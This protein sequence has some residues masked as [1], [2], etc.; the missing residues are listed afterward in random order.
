MSE[1]DFSQ[2]NYPGAGMEMLS[3]AVRQSINPA[4]ARDNEFEARVLTNPVDV[5][6][7]LESEGYKDS[8]NPSPKDNDKKYKFYVQIKG[9][10]SHK[11]NA[12]PCADNPA[13]SQEKRDEIHAINNLYCMVITNHIQKPKIGDIVKI[14]LSRGTFHEFDTRKAKSYLGIS[15]ST[16]EAGLPTAEQ[17]QACDRLSALFDGVSLDELSSTSNGER[18][19]DG[20]YPD[21]NGPEVQRIY[22]LWVSMGGNEETLTKCGGIGGYDVKDCLTKKVA[23]RSVTLHPDFFQKAEAAMN[24]ARKQNFGEKIY[25]GSSKR[26]IK[27]Q[28]RLRLGNQIGTLT[29]KQIVTATSSRFDPPTA[30]LVLTL[31]TGSRH[32]Y[33]LAIDFGGVLQTG[34]TRAAKL[35]NS[36][37]RKSKTFRWMKQNVHKGEFLNTKSEPWHWS[38]DGG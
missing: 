20:K 33:G 37:A 3:H 28:I 7:D 1:I 32:L 4:T 30:P 8:N 12:Q 27:E 15:R 35:S 10:S 21:I 38:A 31:G 29:D 6:R 36:D 16:N 18:S 14:T 23:G 13:Y 26:T 24:A 25:M 19:W 5:N 2:V 17:S 34:G 9:V 22:D 11:F